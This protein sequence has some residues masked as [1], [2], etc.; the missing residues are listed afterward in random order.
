MSNGAEAE[1]IAVNVDPKKNYSVP[2]RAE[3]I[4]LL[5]QV[6]GTAHFPGDRA[7]LVAETITALQKPLL[8]DAH[9]AVP[10]AG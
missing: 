9:G 5:L 4:K 8:D 3:M 6:V 10:D 7:F 1:R 2:L